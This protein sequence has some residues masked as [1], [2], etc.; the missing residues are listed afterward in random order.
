MH[1]IDIDT[2][3][4]EVTLEDGTRLFT[5]AEIRK[6]RSA[7]YRMVGQLTALNN[8]ATSALATFLGIPLEQM[9]DKVAFME[10]AL[11]PRALHEADQTAATGRDHAEY[12]KRAGGFGLR[13]SGKD[14]GSERT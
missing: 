14:R 7:N 11:P 2:L 6:L 1:A 3:L 12:F 4:S 13:P 10:N 8:S 5:D 9:Q